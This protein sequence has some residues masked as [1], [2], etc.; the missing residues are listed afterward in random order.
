MRPLFWNRVLLASPEQ[1]GMP[2]TVDDSKSIWA[3]ISEAEFNNEEFENLFSQGSSAEIE[4]KRESAAMKAAKKSVTGT[5]TFSVLDTK[6]AQRVGILIG[7]LKMDVSAIASA[8]Y[9]MDEN[10][11]AFERVL[12]LYKERLTLEELELI[13]FHKSS[14]L[15]C[16]PLAVPDLFIYELSQI[17]Q[18]GNRVE[19]W[20]FKNSFTERIF[21]VY[22]NME[23]IS[24]GVEVLRADDGS[25]N[26]ILSL[27]LALGNVRNIVDPRLAPRK[28]H[29]SRT[30]DFLEL[31]WRWSIWEERGDFF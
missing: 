27:V 23:T 26:R 2:G 11:I 8:V 6:R 20:I 24:R 19:C 31:C 30:K 15:A 14:E 4:A 3:N 29:C 16:V 13:N 1:Q 22:R 12:G 25:T 28:S 21:E 10:A 9:S 5:E 17:H 7:A 18:F